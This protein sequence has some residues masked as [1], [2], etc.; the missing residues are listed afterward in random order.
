M[1]FPGSW[2]GT[3]PNSSSSISNHG[4]F[5]CKSTIFKGIPMTET[6]KPSGKISD[7]KG[8]GG[9][10]LIAMSR[11]LA[12]CRYGGW[13]TGQVPVKTPEVFQGFMKSMGFLD[14]FGGDEWKHMKTMFLLGVCVCAQ[15]SICPRTPFSHQL[16][17]HL[18]Y[19]DSGSMWTGY[20]LDMAYI[21]LQYLL[22]PNMSQHNPSSTWSQSMGSSANYLSLA[23]IP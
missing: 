1:W 11:A 9:A 21:T 10:H 4:I 6:P 19:N 14:G 23:W 8:E 18:S 16:A 7:P 20:W 2:R 15:F 13:V 17:S 12:L 5:P 22:G 3:P